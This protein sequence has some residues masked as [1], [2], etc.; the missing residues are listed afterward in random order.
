MELLQGSASAQR[1]MESQAARVAHSGKIETTEPLRRQS[2]QALPQTPPA[3]GS[4]QSSINAPA[5]K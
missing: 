4:L 5:P 2:G 1:I 3:F